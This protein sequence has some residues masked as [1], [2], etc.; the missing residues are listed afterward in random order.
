MTRFVIVA[1]LAAAAACGSGST[2]GATGVVSVMNN[3]F[4]P[5]SVQPDLNHAVSWTWNSGGTLHNV[6]FEDLAPGS[7]DRGT[8]A[9]SRDFT[10]AAAGT[11]RY[12]CTIHSA[13]FNSGMVGEVVVP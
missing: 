12:R 7:G 6:T 11:Y 13:D 10:G 5:T 8:G 1:L 2:G 3:S 4:N 9:F